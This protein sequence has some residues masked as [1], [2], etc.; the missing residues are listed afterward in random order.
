MIFCG[1]CGST[2]SGIYKQARNGSHIRYY[3]HRKVDR[4]TAESCTNPTWEKDLVAWRLEEEVWQKAYAY[5]DDPEDAVNKLEPQV[6]S[7]KQRRVPELKQRRAEEEIGIARDEMDKLSQAWAR[8][9]YSD[10]T[11][12][13]NRMAQLGRE[14][15]AV[16]G[17]LSNL[18]TIDRE[19]L[20]ELASLVVAANDP[21]SLLQAWI[22]EGLKNLGMEDYLSNPEVQEFLAAEH[23]E[24]DVDPDKTPLGRRICELRRELLL[25]LGVK[26]TVHG[27]QVNLTGGVPV[28]V[29]SS[30]I[31]SKWCSTSQTCSNP[32]SSAK[33]ACSMACQKV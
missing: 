21:T 4:Q 32:I 10:A 29:D 17:Q 5:F 9:R 22:P 16:Q 23:L 33:V 20:L 14:G 12:L 15:E 3:R 7:P 26:I 19:S 25:Q 6:T 18:A 8:G 11:K 2:Y 27:G 1:G 30:S 24:V 13:E 28:G 31:G